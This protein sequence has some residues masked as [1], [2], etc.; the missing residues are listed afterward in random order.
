MK[1]SELCLVNNTVLGSV[2]PTLLFIMRTMES[3]NDT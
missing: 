3:S 1:E 2:W